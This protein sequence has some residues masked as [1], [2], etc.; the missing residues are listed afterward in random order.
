[1]NL[2]TVLFLLF[3]S[4][5]SKLHIFDAKVTQIPAQKGTRIYFP[6]NGDEASLKLITVKAEKSQIDT[7]IFAFSVPRADGSLNPLVVTADDD[8]VVV[9]RPDG[10]TTPVTLFQDRVT[11]NLNVFPVFENSALQFK[12]GKN[13]YLAV[14]KPNGKILT[15]QNLKVDRQKDG[16]LRAYSGVPGDLIPEP[17]LFF[18]SDIYTDITFYQQLDIPIYEFS[19][20]P[21]FDG[22]SYTVGFGYL[23][24]TLQSSGLIMSP[25]FPITQQPSDMSFNVNRKGNEDISLHMNTYFYRSLSYNTEI[26]V[27]FGFGVENVQSFPSGLNG[28]LG[29]SGKINS[30]EVSSIGAYALQYWTN[31]TATNSEGSTI[32]TGQGTT[33]SIITTTKSSYFMSNSLSI[34]TVIVSLLIG[35]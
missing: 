1:M 18:T 5:Q 30:V 7:N 9:T 17:Y 3:V 4:V 24:K 16:Y 6:T 10:D 27:R 12:A 34:L 31:S 35:C 20:D 2:A 23:T 19:L 26:T 11:E 25:G 14:D 21:V 13:V 32:P 8:T 15:I 22:V 33:P 29:A 28:R